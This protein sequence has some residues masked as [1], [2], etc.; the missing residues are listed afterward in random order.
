VV[1]VAAGG[2]HSCCVTSSGRMFIWGRASYGRLG[3]G[4]DARDA[5]SPVEV[6]L[7]G[8]H[9]RWK[10]AAATAGVCVVL[11]VVGDSVCCDSLN[12]RLNPEAPH[13]CLLLLARALFESATACRQQRAFEQQIGEV[14]CSAEP[15]LALGCT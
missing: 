14:G 5:Y 7:P 3:L 12:L 11:C 2:T 1:Q 15:W 9:Q 10:I 8:G 13:P 6:Q 4:A